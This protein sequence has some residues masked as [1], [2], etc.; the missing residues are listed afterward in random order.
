MVA[1]WE[2]TGQNYMFGP[3]FAFAYGMV[4]AAWDEASQSAIIL[5]ARECAMSLGKPA[6]T[7]WAEFWKKQGYEQRAWD[8]A[9]KGQEATLDRIMQSAAFGND[10]SSSN[11]LI[12]Q[13]AKDKAAIETTAAN[14]RLHWATDAMLFD[15]TISNWALQRARRPS[16]MFFDQPGEPDARG[17]TMRFNF[18]D[19]VDLDSFIFGRLASGA[20]A[21]WDTEVAPVKKLLKQLAD[22]YAPHDHF[23]VNDAIN[24]AVQM[25]YA[26]L[27][28]GCDLGV[29]AQRLEQRQQILAAGQ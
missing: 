11:A 13:F 21:D 6:E 7:S 1:D 2:S 8:Q 18:A 29:L 12:Q 10:P 24:I 15:P 20:E 26:N 28:S 17:C 4:A 16:T 9:W 23:P 19:P 14:F 5:E 25:V 3:D 22:T 27:P